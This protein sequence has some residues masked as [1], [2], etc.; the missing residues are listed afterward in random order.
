MRPIHGV[1]L[2]VA[3]LSTVGIAAFY[4]YAYFRDQQK[5]GARAQS[6][7]FA[8]AQ[9][10]ALGPAEF[11]ARRLKIRNKFF[12]EEVEFGRAAGHAD[13]AALKTGALGLTTVPAC[14]FTSPAALSLRDATGER[15]WAVPVGQP[16][17]VF[18]D[19]GEP[20]CVQ[21]ANFTMESLVN[22]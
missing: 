1:L 18:I 6:F 7:D 12:Y 13:C 9:C 16:A 21:G 3:V 2:A 22:R 10:E 8:G 5:A 4:G 14:Q 19:K 17:T 11:A 20:R 15:F